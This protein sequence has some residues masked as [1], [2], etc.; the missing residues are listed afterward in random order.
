M[1]MKNPTLSPFLTSNFYLSAYLL[2]HGAILSG[3]D[4]DHGGRATF[5]FQS[6]NDTV[7]RVNEFTVGGIA[8]VSAPAFVNAIKHLK[9]LLYDG[10]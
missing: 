8:T 7:Q 3:C 9:A 10:M 5:I 4:R 6:A 2:A 1:S